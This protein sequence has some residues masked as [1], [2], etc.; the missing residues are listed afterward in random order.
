MKNQNILP[1]ISFYKLHCLVAGKRLQRIDF[2]VMFERIAN[3]AFDTQDNEEYYRA[4]CT[5]LDSQYLWICMRHGAPIPRNPELLDTNVPKANI[6][7]ERTT[8][9]I[10]LNRQIFI[11]FDKTTE[12]AYISNLKK[13]DFIKNSISKELQNKVLLKRAINPGDKNLMEIS[14]LKRVRFTDRNKI[15]RREFPD[16]KQRIGT[17]VGLDAEFI[18][19]LILKPRKR[20]ILSKTQGFSNFFANSI[21][22]N[23]E[24]IVIG[25]DDRGIEVLYN[26]ETFTK[27]YIISS[28]K[29]ENGFYE[30]DK[31][32][33]DLITEIHFKSS[34]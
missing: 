3:K 24:L 16:I 6:K 30:S 31:L 27:K 9:Q 28:P 34:N 21:D 5:L 17:M 29:D 18:V 7:N 12:C 25:K 13:M 8:Q 1:N 22:G 2:D 23:E 32:L 20:K 33:R 26:D 14:T 10:E 15:M 19:E 4:E 11:L